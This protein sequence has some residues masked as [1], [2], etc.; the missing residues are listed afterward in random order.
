[1]EWG[2]IKKDILTSQ[3]EQCGS[4]NL[5][6]DSMSG[7]GRINFIVKMSGLLWNEG[8]KLRRNQEHLWSSGLRNSVGSGPIYWDV[9]E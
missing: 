2:D 7:K 8:S 6:G 9:K 5:G 1:M 3:R 4:F